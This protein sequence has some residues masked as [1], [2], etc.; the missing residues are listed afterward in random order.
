MVIC[1]ISEM[2]VPAGFQDRNTTSCAAATASGY[3]L[4]LW[5][6]VHH[7]QD[8]CGIDPPGVPAATVQHLHFHPGLQ[9][10]FHHHRYRKLSPG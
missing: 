1:V 3:S 8:F 6:L 4:G 2:G 10:T 7:G 9:P 5:M